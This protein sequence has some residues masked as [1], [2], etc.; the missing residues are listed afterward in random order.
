MIDGVSTHPEFGGLSVAVA[1]GDQLVVDRGYDIADLEWNA[2][3]DASTS[4]RIGSLT[5]QFTAAAILK[6]AEQGKLGLEDPLSRYV[7]EF[8]TAR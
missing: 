2:P 1:R 4:F 6:L 5:K 8:D 3:A 7:P